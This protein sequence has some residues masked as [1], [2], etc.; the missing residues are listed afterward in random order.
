MEE[1]S[2]TYKI[3]LRWHEGRLGKDSLR[4][5]SESNKNKVPTPASDI[6]IS[7]L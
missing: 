2:D 3:R 1:V 7:S 5:K 6:Y 4:D